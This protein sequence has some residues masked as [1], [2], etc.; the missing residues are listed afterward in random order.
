MYIRILFILLVASLVGCNSTTYNSLG[1]SNYTSSANRLQ[2]NISKKHPVTYL[3]LASVLFEQG[4]K[5]Q[6]V[7]WYYV[8]QIRY[9]AHL[10]ANP[11]LDPSGDPAIYASLKYGLGPLINAYAGE[12]LCNWE[13]LI[14]SALTWH[15]TN[16]NTF[17]PKDEYPEIY[18][19]I[20]SG[21]DEFRKQVSNNKEEI[22]KTREANG[23]SNR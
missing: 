17:T 9:R 22:R 2:N 7:V 15:K 19:K 8:G 5:D 18:K 12:D 4:Q 16:P 20:E 3:E 6:A 1:K 21:F 13:K 11:D 10:M 23:L 14:A